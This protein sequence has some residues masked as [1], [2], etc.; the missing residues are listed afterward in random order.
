MDLGSSSTSSR[1]PCPE[2]EEHGAFWAS[3]LLTKPPL[4]TFTQSI[5]KKGYAQKRGPSNR[6]FLNWKRVFLVLHF[7]FLSYFPSNDPK[8][9]CDG[10][11]YLP[12]MTHELL[13][14]YPAVK[15]VLKICPRVRRNLHHVAA[16]DDDDNFYFSFESAATLS[17]WVDAF[18][19]EVIRAENSEQ[20]LCSDDDD[21]TKALRISAAN[22]GG[23]QDRDTDGGHTDVV[24]E[25]NETMTT[26]L[27]S[28]TL[29]HQADSA[30]RKT[31][32]DPHDL[33][34]FKRKSFFASTETVKAYNC[35]VVHHNHCVA[36]K[37]API[38][39]FMYSCV[40]CEGVNLCGSCF[41][42][43]DH[44]PRHLFMVAPD[45]DGECLRLAPSIEGTN[46]PF[47][48]VE[49][50]VLESMFRVI[51]G[52]MDGAITKSISKRRMTSFWRNS[53]IDERLSVTEKDLL[54]L[55]RHHATISFEEFVFLV[56][57]R[58]ALPSAFSSLEQPEETPPSMV[59]GGVA[60]WTGFSLIAA[61]VDRLAAMLRAAQRGRDIVAFRTAMQELKDDSGKRTFCL[62]ER[63][64]LNVV[65]S[66]VS[67][68]VPQLGSVVPVDLLEVIF[69]RLAVLASTLTP[70]PQGNG[71]SN[72]PGQFQ[73][74]TSFSGFDSY[75]VHYLE[76]GQIGSAASGEDGAR[77]VVIVT[78]VEPAVEFEWRRLG[79]DNL[80]LQAQD[81]AF[82]SNG[83]RLCDVLESVLCFELCQG[84]GFY[85]T[86]PESIHPLG[87]NQC[88][89][90]P[91]VGYAFK[92]SVCLD[93][94]LCLRCFQE[95]PHERHHTFSRYPGGAV[96][97]AP[98]VKPLPATST[99]STVT[100]GARLAASNETPEVRN[101]RKVGF[102]VA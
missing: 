21:E 61:S 101:L 52:D 16:S 48:S 14:H 47:R 46:K 68:D 78:D 4:A 19:A 70:P 23:H 49:L 75:P 66:A 51:G 76:Q 25:L 8:A 83:H 67:F 6:N 31:Q 27:L 17:E 53:G 55:C 94:D 9:K 81:G 34:D 39:G 32:R 13:K 77:G 50:V 87:C 79:L 97:S 82:A 22:G 1:L 89:V 11:I 60:T 59:G 35:E 26:D 85:T 54:A 28:S 38:Y 98:K 88:G 15:N 2:D 57:C 71:S 10:I 36:C 58:L 95:S 41:R 29:R 24:S 86:Q 72:S 5:A 80:I 91:I 43:C 42:E 62:L 93:F 37:M 99:Q 73:G 69:D 74:G 7:P 96:L 33:S 56:R 12:G 20:F 92:C 65:V 63:A 64:A 40:S 90:C 30:T 18:Q 44:D 84:L 3:V 102:V 45:V 100:S